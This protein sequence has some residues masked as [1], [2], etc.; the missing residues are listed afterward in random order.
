MKAR[1]GATAANTAAAHKLARIIYRLVTTKQPYDESV[2]N[3]INERFKQKRIQ[4]LQKEAELLGYKFG[5]A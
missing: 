3:N 1:F 4:K 2:F 5:I